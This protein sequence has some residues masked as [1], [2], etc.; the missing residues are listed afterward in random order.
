MIRDRFAADMRRD[1][2][3]AASVQEAAGSPG[4]IAVV[5]VRRRWT[6]DGHPYHE[7]RLFG[8]DRLTIWLDP[9]RRTAV[10]VLCLDRW[11]RIDWRRDHDVY[12]DLRMIRRAPDVDEPGWVPD[13]DSTFGSRARG[14][15]PV[16]CA[17]GHV[18]TEHLLDQLDITFA[19]TQEATA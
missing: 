3:F 16:H 18:W 14:H 10:L 7:V 11:P 15:D 2:E 5:R 19:G 4:P 13:M 12:P 17:P 9:D 6:R 1:G 8:A